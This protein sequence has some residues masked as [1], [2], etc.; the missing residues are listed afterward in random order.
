MFNVSPAF[1][2]AETEEPQ[3]ATETIFTQALQP[4]FAH[5]LSVEGLGIMLT[6]CPSKL[7]VMGAAVVGALAELLPAC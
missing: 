5:M 2:G 4:N 6:T 7:Q 3:A 1:I